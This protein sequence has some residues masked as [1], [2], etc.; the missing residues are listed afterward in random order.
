MSRKVSRELGRKLRKK[1]RGRV[2]GSHTHPGLPPLVGVGLLDVPQSG[3]GLQR[4]RLE[5]GACKI[6]INEVKEK[7]IHPHL[8]SKIKLPYRKIIFCKIYANY[9]QYKPRLNQYLNSALN[10]CPCAMLADKA[11]GCGASLVRV[12]VQSCN[13]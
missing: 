7:V 4:I 13:E 1:T 11:C 5:L 2:K 12:G 6:H 8:T 3:P 10:S 9:K